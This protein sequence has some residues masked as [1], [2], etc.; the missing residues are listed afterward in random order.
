MRV[1][2]TGAAGSVGTMTRA[3]LKGCFERFVVSDIRPI[4][5]RH[6]GEEYAR[7]DITNLGQMEK[8]LEGA[9]GVIH[10]GGQPVEA[11]WESVLNLN[12]IGLYNT[13]EAAR[14]QGV[15]RIVFATTNHVVGFYRRSRTIDHTAMPRP[16]SRYGASKAF[17]EALGRLYADKYGLRVFNIRIGNADHRPVDIRRLAIWVSPRDLAQLMRIGL[18]HP[19]IHFEVVYGASRCHRGWWDNSNAHR[20]GYRPQDEAEDYAKEAHEAGSRN[21]ED[22]ITAQFHG[23][24]FSAMEF[25]GDPKR[26]D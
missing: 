7:A 11:D 8:L 23:G 9:D 24:P 13:Y 15:K 6:E 17:G 22:P 10:L 26:I 21:P 5:D 16:D 20:L 18:E 25:A 19:D 3:H 14:R 1:V 12:I 4:D 2:M